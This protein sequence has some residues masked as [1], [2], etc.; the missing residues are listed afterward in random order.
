MVNLARCQDDILRVASQKHSDGFV[1]QYSFPV[2]TPKSTQ[3]DIRRKKALHT[4]ASQKEQVIS[5]IVGFQVPN[6]LKGFIKNLSLC[7]VTL[8]QESCKQQQSVMKV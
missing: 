6:R 5:R 4:V 8:C 7:G 2:G 1:F 3:K